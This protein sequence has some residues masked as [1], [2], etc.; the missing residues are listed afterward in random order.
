METQIYSVCFLCDDSIDFCIPD[1]VICKSLSLLLVFVERNLSLTQTFAL[2]A[3]SAAGAS[4]L[5][6]WIFGF[7]GI[8]LHEDFV[9]RAG[10]CF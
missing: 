7:T 2:T 6:S 1:S 4:F 10:D 3:S 8:S 9:P 5:L